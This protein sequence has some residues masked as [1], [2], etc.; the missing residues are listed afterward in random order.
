MRQR[1]RK[2]INKS[3]LDKLLKQGFG[4]RPDYLLVLD[5]GEI[6][7][8]EETGRPE[9]KDV[10]RVMDFA[11]MLRKGELHLPGITVLSSITGV[12]HYKRRD[13]AFGKYLVSQQKKAWRELRI[14]LLGVS[15]NREFQQRLR[16]ALG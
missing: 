3:S 12:I 16:I 14:R 7:V 15:C 9:F 10:K 5:D 6:I 1:R 4:K 11:T 2:V 13:S 8:V